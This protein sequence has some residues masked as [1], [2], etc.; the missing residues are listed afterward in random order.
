MIL[1]WVVRV[2]LVVTGFIIG[3]LVAFFAFAN[4]FWDAGTAQELLTRS[5]PTAQDRLDLITRLVGVAAA[6]FVAY[7]TR[8]LTSP[9]ASPSEEDA[10]RWRAGIVGCF[11]LVLVS[12]GGSGLWGA[13]F[14]LPVALAV[15]ALGGWVTFRVSCGRAR[16]GTSP[17]P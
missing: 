4:F 5:F 3:D 17:A 7:R 13:G 10:A 9:G 15:A 6:S 1:R 16:S 14:G 2:V 8:R 12:W 11:L